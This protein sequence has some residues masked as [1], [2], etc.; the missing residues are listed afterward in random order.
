MKLLLAKEKKMT[1]IE[2]EKNYSYEQTFGLMHAN[3]LLMQYHYF[4]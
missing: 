1:K 4:Y 3:A 2:E